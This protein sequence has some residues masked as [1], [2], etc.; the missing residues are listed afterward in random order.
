VRKVTLALQAGPVPRDPR[1]L[2]DRKVS[3]VTGE[4]QDPME[5]MVGMEIQETPVLL[6]QL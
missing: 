6:D 1:V 2:L 4:I 5:L 3:L